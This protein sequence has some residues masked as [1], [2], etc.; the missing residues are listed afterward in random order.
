MENVIHPIN[1]AL[2][3][4]DKAAF[5]SQLGASF[6]Q[7]GFA[8]V[9]GHF[10]AEQVIAQGLETAQNFFAL[11]PEVKAKY[12][13]AD[14]GFQRGHAPLGSENAKGRAQGD[15]KEFWHIGR[16][17]VP[18]SDISD[19]A[20]QDEI[21]ATPSVADVPDF[22][23]ATQALFAQFD[24]FGCHILRAVAL[25]LDLDERWFDEAIDQGNSLLRLL[26]YPPQPIAPSNGAVRAAEHQDINLITLLLGAQEAGL[27]VKHKRYGWIDVN[28]PDGAIVLNCGDMLERLTGGV[29]PST[30][31]RV[32]NPK[33]HRA[34]FSRYSMPFFL[35]PKN[36]FMIETLP[37]CLAQG[38]LAQP[39]IRAGDYLRERL[40]EIGLLS[41]A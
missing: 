25:Y 18:K 2:W 16:P 36:S 7:T 4:T 41:A 14:I 8:V 12:Q 30:T 38:G 10:I 13:R 32:S 31:H 1:F 6:R 3:Q 40:V 19:N 20:E 35:H 34:Q 5:A 29:L 17:D 22:D 28:V 33:P 23:H 27:Q 37:S 24:D 21:L 9:E 26:H 15:M 39:P 11:P